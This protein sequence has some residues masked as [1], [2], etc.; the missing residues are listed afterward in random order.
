MGHDDDLAAGIILRFSPN[1]ERKRRHRYQHIF[2]PVL[3]SLQT[4]MRATVSDFVKFVQYYKKNL[5]N[6]PLMA[7][8]EIAMTKISV[9]F[10]LVVLPL[11]VNPSTTYILIGIG[12]MFIISGWLMSFVFQVA[13][14]VEDTEHPVPTEDSTIENARIIHEVQT[15]ANFGMKNKFITRWVGGLNYQIEHHLFP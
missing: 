5:F 15:S 13:H 11:L 9:W 2:G 10:L 8:G 4:F 3:Y 7:L 6:K 12:I 14:I 1:D